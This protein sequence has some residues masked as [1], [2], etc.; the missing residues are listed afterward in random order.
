MDSIWETTRYRFLKG[1]TERKC[2]RCGADLNVKLL[3]DLKTAE[4]QCSDSLIINY[5]TEEK[6]REFG[7]M[8][9]RRKVV[10]DD[11]IISIEWDDRLKAFIIVK[12]KK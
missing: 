10:T 9:K 1:Y 7:L 6:L 3:P 8:P 4:V 5:V 2:F 12:M 11:P